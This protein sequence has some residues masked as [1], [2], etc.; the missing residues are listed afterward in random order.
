[1]GQPPLLAPPAQDQH[2]PFNAQHHQ[3]RLQLQHQSRYEPLFNS[4]F[5]VRRPVPQQTEVP[6]AW[7][8]EAI[9]RQ[10]VSAFAG[11]LPYTLQGSRQQQQQQRETSLPFGFSGESSLLDCLEVVVCSVLA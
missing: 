4:V 10:P 3:E 5:N 1:M 9:P 6:T 7:G 11:S 8:P 2:Q